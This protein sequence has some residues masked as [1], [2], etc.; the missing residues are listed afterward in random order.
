VTFRGGRPRI[1][2]LPRTVRQKGTHPV[3]RA[4]QPILSAFPRPAGPRRGFTLNELLIVMGLIVIILA[5]ALPAF[6]LISGN[7]SVESAENQISAYLAVA[8][9]EATGLQ[10]PRGVM[11]FT[12]PATGRVTMLQVYYPIPTTSTATPTKAIDLF[13]GRDEVVLPKGVGLIG[14]PTENL[15]APGIP[16]I[17][18]GQEDTWRQY[19]IIM[20]D[21]DGRLL[22]DKWTIAATTGLAKRLGTNTA[23]GLVFSTPAAG[24][25]S[26][27]IGFALYE[28]AGYETVKTQAAANRRTWLEENYIP[29]LIN[30]Y[31]GTLL[32]AH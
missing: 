29:Y 13:P 7:R 8:R 5:I 2:D 23:P 20:F 3:H 15:T 17:Q 19:A 32:K 1:A 26:A 16:T 22:L 24:T 10:E 12:D 18:T 21:G 30:R 31:N 6:N 9:S 4:N 14:V 11:M 27:N 25:T 28:T